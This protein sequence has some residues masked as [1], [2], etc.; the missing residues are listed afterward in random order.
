LEGPE[1][2]AAPHDQ[3]LAEP[4]GDLPAHAERAGAAGDAEPLR[5]GCGWGEGQ[6]GERE[7]ERT[8]LHR[9]ILAGG[10]PAAS[11]ER[12]WEHTWPKIDLFP[13]RSRDS[14]ARAS[15]R[16]ATG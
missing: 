10:G 9:A 5:P 8:R 14:R 13:G 7:G 1:A 16:R 4:D 3:A 2:R 12:G 11:D 6:H 15:V